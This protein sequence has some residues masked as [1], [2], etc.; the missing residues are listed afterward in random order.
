MTDLEAS[1][2]DLIS[3]YLAGDMDAAELND[4]LPDGWDLDEAD[5]PGASELALLA[6]GFLAGYQSGDRDEDALRIAL[7]GLISDTIQVEYET[8]DMVEV[9]ASRIAAS[10]QVAVEGDSSLGEGFEQAASQHPQTE[11]RTTTAL[12]DPLGTR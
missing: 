6:L 12:P 9:L 1:I 3:R 10:I 5:D 8:G 4:L 7:A 2:R 11:H